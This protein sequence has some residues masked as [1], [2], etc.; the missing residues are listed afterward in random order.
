MGGHRTGYVGI[1]GNTDSRGDP[2]KAFDVSISG[3]KVA[4]AGIAAEGVLTSILTF[5]IRKGGVE[6]LEFRLGGMDSKSGD[7]FDWAY[8]E[9]SVGDVLTIR[10]VD[11]PR[12][13]SLRS[14]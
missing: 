11:V 7:H 3:E 13:M 14:V 10:I 4:T 6:H 5:A 9:P 8:R 2:V 1:R 12:W